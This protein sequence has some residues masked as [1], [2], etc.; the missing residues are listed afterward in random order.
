M[1]NTRTEEKDPKFKVISDLPWCEHEINERLAAYR[2]L[3]DKGGAGM[4]CA[5]CTEKL[6]F[7]W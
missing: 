2:Q 1:G 4:A 5:S 7:S 6:I 3:S